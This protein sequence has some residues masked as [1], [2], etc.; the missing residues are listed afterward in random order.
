[1][2]KWTYTLDLRNTWPLDNPYAV[3][4]DIVRGLTK[5]RINGDWMLDD[6]ID[7]FSEMEEGVGYEEFNEAMDELYDWAD[8]AR[9][10]VKR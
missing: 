5:L 7:T 3:A 4:Q 2:N 8:A 10:W 1:M 9:C 6:L